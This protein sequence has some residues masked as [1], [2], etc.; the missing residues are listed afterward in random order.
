MAEV[1]AALPRGLELFASVRRQK[2]LRIT[3]PRAAAL[4][5]LGIRSVQD[6]LQHYPRRH[7]DRTAL[8]TVAD[9]REM[10]ARGELGEVQ[11]LGKVKQMGKPFELRGKPGSRSKR[12][13]I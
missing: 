5:K 12:T 6:L 11:I 10:A 7:V 9:I 3:G 1:V 4:E 2:P 8:K 13:M